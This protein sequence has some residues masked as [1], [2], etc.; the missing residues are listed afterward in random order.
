VTD[1]VPVTRGRSRERARVVA[2]AAAGS[3][4]LLLTSGRTWMTVRSAG[5]LA[6]PPVRLDARDLA[7]GVPALALL[8]LAGAAGLLAARGLV[9]RLVALVLAA[10]GLGAAVLA[11]VAAYAPGAGDSA[12]RAA[13]ERLPGGGNATAGASAW[14][15][16]AVV[17][18]LVV[19]LAGAY[20]VARSARW[21]ALGGRYDA[22]GEVRNARAAA[23]PDRD[24]WRALDAGD[25]PTA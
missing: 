12:L 25:D 5:P 7:P 19:L 8:G 2:A 17:G 16:I 1:D 22:P 11:G 15:A 9:R 24:A 6:V 20:A 14:P 4:L 18:G 3:L 13:G 21:S 23:S 10:A